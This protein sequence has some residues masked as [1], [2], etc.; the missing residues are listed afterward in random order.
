MATITTASGRV[1]ERA[2]PARRKTAPRTKPQKKHVASGK[3][4]V[5]SEEPALGWTCNSCGQWH[6]QS[7]IP[8]RCT[9]C[10]R[11]EFDEVGK[12][13]IRNLKSEIAPHGAEMLVP[14]ADIVPSPY[15]PRTEF[16]AEE[17]RKLAD[18]IAKHGLVQKIVVRLVD[19][20]PELVAGERRLRAVKLLGW[21]QVK[22]E[23]RELDDVAACEIVIIENF[24]RQDLSPFDEAAGFANW[25]ELTGSTQTAC[26]ERFK[27][28]QG[29]ISNRLRL[30]K[31]GLGFRQEVT[32]GRITI[33]QAREL[34]THLDLPGFEAAAWSEWESVLD[35]ND[36]GELPLPPGDFVWDVICC[37]LHRCTRQINGHGP[38]NSQLGD[39]EKRFK[40]RAEQREALAIVTLAM[41]SRYSTNKPQEY[42]TNVA[43]WDE[44]Q[45]AH[46][47][48]LLAKKKG[49]PA[50]ESEQAAKSTPKKP[51]TAAEQK[52]EA[53]AEAARRKRADEVL[54]KRADEW[55]THWLRRLIH[56]RLQEDA[57]RMPIA[58]RLAVHLICDTNWDTHRR[59]LAGV[60][61][62][63]IK[64]RGGKVRKSGYYSHD[65][66]GSVCGLELDEEQDVE[67]LLQEALLETLVDSDSGEPHLALS[68]DVV[69]RLAEFCR[70][71]LAEQWQLL[72]KKWRLRHRE[73]DH[74]DLLF[75]AMNKDQL[76]DYGTLAKVPKKQLVGKK[77][78]LIKAICNSGKDLP[79]PKQL[80]AVKL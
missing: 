72:D 23:V 76:I 58:R 6:Q 21:E 79:V 16:D 75:A 35:A 77:E 42:A 51:L 52:A 28:T 65:I 46:V 71:D 64:A 8:V 30:L 62:A 48:K 63:G 32:A 39:H 9:N 13:E 31:L 61:A 49:Q 43:L 2:K 15:Q 29:Q 1:T 40:P 22:A 56:A 59:H 53:Q 20:T 3:S 80:K 54:Q 73:A 26:A 55:R 19:G 47:E 67:D 14:V 36:D 50:P 74:L 44:L 7:A 24:D 66:L 57:W 18:S 41:P 17:I 27:L 10:G 11:Q 38:W 60:V 12:S 68:S 37:G 78:D 25:M 69:E 4:H 45:K 34:C 33:K 70:F 5:A